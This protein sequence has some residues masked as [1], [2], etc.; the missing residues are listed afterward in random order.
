MSLKDRLRQKSDALVRREDVTLPRTGERI[1][2]RGLMAGE[3]LRCA[4]LTGAKQ[5]ATMIAL[6]V[7]DPDTKRPL[8]NAHAAE[9][10]ENIGALHSD[11]LTAILNAITGLSGMGKEGQEAAK[12][13]EATESSSSSS[14][15]GTGSSPTSL[16]AA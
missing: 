6:C 11:D 13:S 7:E 5:T 4:E 1:T 3:Q 8:W 15:S 10:H 16:D 14:R 12:N 2:V 9:D